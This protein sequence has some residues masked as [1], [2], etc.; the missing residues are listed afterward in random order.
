[1]LVVIV[2]DGEFLSPSIIQAYTE[3]RFVIALDGAVNRL[4]ALHILPDVILGDLDSIED[5]SHWGI[6]E[7][8]NTYEGAF[9]IQIVPALDQNHTDLDKAITYAK[10]QGAKEILILCALGG[11]SDHHLM[12]LRL[13]KT[14]YDPEIILSIVS[15][16][17][18]LRYA[19]DTNVTWSAPVGALCAVMAFPEA[20][21]NTDGLRYELQDFHLCFAKS[22]SAC[23]QFSKNQCTFEVHGEA[24]LILPAKK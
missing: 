4:R 9:G 18:I 23:N 6:V 12:N 1:M 21:V 13:L 10:Q 11:R 20:I 16:T 8:E 17:E 22:E 19:K 14:H 3:K 2:A 15:E 7:S 5:R 24:L